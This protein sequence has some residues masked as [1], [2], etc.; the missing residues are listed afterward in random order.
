[1]QM[2]LYKAVV[3]KFEINFFILIIV[4]EKIM[5]KERLLCE[6]LE[7]CRS[8]VLFEEASKA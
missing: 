3:L 8:L 5:K 7:K 1:M 4:M 6:E 2:V